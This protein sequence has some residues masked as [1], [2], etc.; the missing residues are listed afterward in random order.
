MGAIT[1]VTGGCRSG[2]SAFA[3][4]YAEKRATNRTYI[5]TCR[6]CD[7]EM[8]RRVRCHK[9]ERKERNWDTVEEPLDI[10]SA[11][12]SVKDGV[13]LIDCLTIWVSNL[14]EKAHSEGKEITETEIK[15]EAERLIDACGRASCSVTLVTNEVGMGIV[16]ENHLARRFRDLAGLVN[17]IIANAACEV[18]LIVSGQAISIKKG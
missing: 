12:E 1:L 14:M 8:E 18:Y 6:P 17:Q 15:S 16:P 4:S 3:L 10:A 5:A 9:E 7:D 2:K 13:A 11:L